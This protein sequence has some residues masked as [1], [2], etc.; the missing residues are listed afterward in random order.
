MED[1]LKEM[2]QQEWIQEGLKSLE[3]YQRTKR[4]ITLKELC[5]WLQTWGTEDEDKVPQCHK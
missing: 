2:K 5:D 3:H 1:K 4:H